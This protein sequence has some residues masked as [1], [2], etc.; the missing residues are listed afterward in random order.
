MSSKKKSRPNQSRQSV[1]QSQ[2][3]ALQKNRDSSP[4]AASGRKIPQPIRRFFWGLVTASLVAPAFILG[5]QWRG[6]SWTWE[7]AAGA[8]AV[9]FVVFLFLATIRDYQK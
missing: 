8:S 9:M 7:E 2:R 4:G 5:K 1:G 3:V 6:E